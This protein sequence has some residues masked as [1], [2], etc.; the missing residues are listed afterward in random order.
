MPVRKTRRN[1]RHLFQLRFR[2][3][4]RFESTKKKEK[5]VVRKSCKEEK[6]LWH[7]INHR[8]KGKDDTLHKCNQNGKRE[9]KGKSRVSYKNQSEGEVRDG[10]RNLGGRNY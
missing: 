10:E 3:G 9:M 6:S 5:K 2:E 8:P 1:R 7:S 4:D